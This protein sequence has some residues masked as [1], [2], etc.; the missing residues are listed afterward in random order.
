MTSIHSIDGG[1]WATAAGALETMNPSRPAGDPGRGRRRESMAATPLEDGVDLGPDPARSQ[2]AA[3]IFGG[4]QIYAVRD[5]EGAGGIEPAGCCPPP[6]S[7]PVD[8]WDPID[9]QGVGEV[10]FQLDQMFDRLDHRVKMAI[11]KNFLV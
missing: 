2:A 4:P 10:Q 11:I 1:Y 6:G 3:V 5:A 8:S 9:S 7:E